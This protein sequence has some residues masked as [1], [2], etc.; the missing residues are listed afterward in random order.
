MSEFGKGFIYSLINFAKH[1][2]RA[3]ADMETYQRMRESSKNKASKEL[4]T[5]ERALSVWINGASDHLYEL[6][7]PNN[8]PKNIKNKIEKLQNKAFDYGHG[9]RP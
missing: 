4:F 8:L 1:F 9:F 6:E 3:Y 5:P 2:D 7:Y